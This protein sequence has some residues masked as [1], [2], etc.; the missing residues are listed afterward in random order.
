MK[1]NFPKV[2]YLFSQCVSWNT[3]RDL[4]NDFQ[5][6]VKV[7]GFVDIGVCFAHDNRH[8]HVSGQCT[9]LPAM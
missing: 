9:P 1:I 2:L 8:R 3:F 6:A 4:S 5:I 7:C